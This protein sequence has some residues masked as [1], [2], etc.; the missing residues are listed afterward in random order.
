M[1]GAALFV[2][3]FL[4][5]GWLRPGYDTRSMF[6]SELALGPRGW[7]QSANFIIWGV[8]LFL[9]ARGVA[10]EVQGGRAWRAGPILLMISAVCFVASGFFVM[11]PVSTPRDQMSLHGTL[12]NLFGAVVF[13]LA[14]ISCFVF[15]RTF[16]R[17]RDWQ[18]LQMWTLAA[19]TITA[20][21]LVFMSVGPT[22]A[23]A[24]PNAFNAW[25]GV[26]QRTILITYLAWIFT[27]ARRLLRLTR[28]HAHIPTS[29][30]E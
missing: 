12:H 16:R 18:R 19:G 11:D 14:P 6:V 10:G 13:L 24:T 1:V 22:K 3:V 29:I 7:I 30:A 17:D 23:P 27:F 8:L 9:F 4:I 26:I 21:V 15:L 2:A 28:E 25:N 20:L 5:E